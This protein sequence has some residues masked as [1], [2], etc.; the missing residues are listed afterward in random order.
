M[1][2]LCQNF[3]LCLDYEKT[4]TGSRTNFERGVL[5]KFDGFY[6][7]NTIQNKL[8]AFENLK[9]NHRW[10]KVKKMNYLFPSFIRFSRTISRCYRFFLSSIVKDVKAEG[11]L[12]SFYTEKRLSNE[13]I[14]WH[15]LIK[16]KEKPFSWVNLI[17]FY[18]LPRVSSREIYKYLL[19]HEYFNDQ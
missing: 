9:T 19:R 15:A 17:K 14:F 4:K 3:T 7:L 11:N 16:W 6:W 8:L 2:F 13:N 1:K 5:N 12:I 10:K 18:F